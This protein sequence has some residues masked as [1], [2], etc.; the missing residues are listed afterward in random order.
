MPP[1]NQPTDFFR[2]SFE[3]LNHCAGIASRKFEAENPKGV[4]LTQMTALR[5]L[6]AKGPMP[7]RRLAEHSGI[8]RSTMSAM[9]RTLH[10][11]GLVTLYR[12]QDDKRVVKVTITSR[13]LA[14]LEIAE[15]AAYHVELAFTNGLH[16]R[17][18]TAFY[19]A[20]TRIAGASGD[21]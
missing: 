2:H 21:A 17:D 19:K 13:G 4:T 16:G 11:R 5:V 15:E 20:L 12:P 8:D 14:R 6:K 10:G 1:K 7:Q 9:L 18:L 3:L